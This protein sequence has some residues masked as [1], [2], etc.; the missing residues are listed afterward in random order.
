MC[1]ISCL[2][3]GA[4]K[5]SKQDVEGK[6][7]LEVGSFTS[8]IKGSLRM[9][10]E[11]WSPAEYIGVDIR[12]G[13]SVDLVY[14]AEKLMD[15]LEAESFDVVFSTELLEH[16]LNPKIVISN[17]KRLCKRRGAILLTTRSYGYPF[18]PSPYDFWR[19]EPSDMEALFSD[20]EI[21]NLE[22]DFESPGVFVKVRKPDDFVERDL[23]ELKLYN[24]AV[25]KKVEKV[26]LSDIP[27]KLRLE[28]D[29]YHA[30]RSVTSAFMRAFETLITTVFKSI[31]Q[32]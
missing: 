23:S 11:S 24:I 6:R 17:M 1:T 14:D 9:L 27:K 4:T 15:K 29:V 30:V 19:F 3:F 26:T 5:L 22:E 10:I 16:V 18:H 31:K 25:N 21:L 28:L 12:K 8:D 2:L 32:K 20:C 7:V 13:P